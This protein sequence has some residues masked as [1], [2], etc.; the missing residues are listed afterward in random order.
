[1]RWKGSLVRPGSGIRRPMLLTKTTRRVR[2]TR[3]MSCTSEWAW[4]LYHQS[5]PAMQT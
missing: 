2:A 3:R 5:M 1:M 4:L